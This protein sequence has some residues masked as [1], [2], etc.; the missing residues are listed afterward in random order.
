MESIH[1]LLGLLLFGIFII[2]D[3]VLYAFN[4]A[5]SAVNRSSLEKKNE[6]GDK[7]A[8]FALK[9][10]DEPLNFTNTLDVTVFIT[11][12]AVGAYILRAVAE[13]CDKY[14]NLDNTLVLW[15]TALIIVLVLIVAGVIVPKRL[16]L[17][18]PEKY[19][20]K[21]GHFV[22]VYSRIVLPVTLIVSVISRPI[23]RLCRI[24]PNEETDNVTEEEI[25]T[26]V[27]E[28]QEHGVLEASEAE[29]IT[30]IFE[31]G[32][33]Q[34]HEVMIHRSNMVYLNSDST[35]EE[36]FRF[37]MNENF[38]RY[39]VCEEDIDT[40]VGLVYLRD[41]VKVYEEAD[42]EKKKCRITEIEHLIREACFIPETRNIDGLFKEMKAKKIH[43][44]IVV[45]EYGQT[46]GIVTMED[47]IEEIVGN[48]FD[49]YDEEEELIEK[50]AE[51]SYEVD[52]LMLLDDL[53]ETLNITFDTEDYETVN[54]FMIS[55]M[56][57]LPTDNED[58]VV[59]YMGYKF[60]VLEASARVIRKVKITRINETEA[61]DDADTDN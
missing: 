36:T 4:G 2:L 10:L 38:S 35:L 46:S 19:V 41:V 27:N 12:I 8:G 48:I 23:L 25:I 21:Y 13:F 9:I 32:E 57:R 31:F 17:K 26:M 28:G 51:D 29:M 1:P 11:N 49:E 20:L 5:L 45:D 44:A 18:F 30:N 6:E 54:G 14:I 22:Y 15:I 56:H 55:N 47:I 16:G 52:G 61:T 50:T 34:A 59:E 60:M 33:K 3:C 40:I 58:A 7:S 37:M 43:L 53:E 42:D 24:N 39:P